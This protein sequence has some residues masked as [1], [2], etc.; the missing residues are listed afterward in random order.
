MK[1]SK[2]F[3]RLIETP[4]GKYFFDVN[5]DEIYNLKDKVFES[6]YNL[7][8]NKIETI[9]NSILE[10]NEMQDY[11]LLKNTRPQKMK[12]PEWDF[13]DYHLNHKLDSITLQLTQKCNFRCTYCIY[14]QDTSL[15]RSH[16]SNT[17]TINVAKEAVDFLLN[18]SRDCDSV[19][20]GFYGGEP[21]LE[22]KLLKEIVLY[23]KSVFA[24]KPI[25]F[26]LT[27]NCSLINDEVIDFFYLHSI[28]VLISLDGPKDIH[29]SKR[30]FAVNG[31]GTFDTIMEKLNMIK[32]KYPDYYMKNISFNTVVD[33][34]KEFDCINQMYISNELLNISQSSM[35]SLIDDTY[36]VGKNKYSDEFIQQHSYEGFK[37]FLCE[38]GRINDENL[39]VISRQWLAQEKQFKK[40]L[41]TAKIYKEMSHGGPCI[42]GRK[43]F[44]DTKG[45]LYPCERV[46]ESSEAMQIGNI[47][48]GFNMEKIDKLMN[49]AKL[50]EK[51]CKECWAVA[52]CSMCAKSAD[53]GTTLCAERI[54][55]GCSGVKADLDYK[56]RRYIAIKEIKA[57]GII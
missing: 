16:S 1:S 45:N 11:G 9:D 47:Q 40:T 22:F 7:S 42:I 55:E 29:N 35:H 14:G 23:A 24:G 54:L 56:L 4:Y 20:I 27:T 53:N 15:Q 10:I 25:M 13:M 32:R 39:S 26:H 17:M 37:V 3:I 52:R 8:T 5:T 36:S 38:L 30:V 12:H 41:G 57:G 44:I 31:C 21:L 50:T 33:P 2:P 46:S 6:L 43:T 49:V 19:S 51:Q 34:S 28:N 18:R 48:S